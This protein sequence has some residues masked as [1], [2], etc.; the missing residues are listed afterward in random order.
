M[1]Q[2]ASQR[3]ILRVAGGRCL[4]QIDAIATEAPLELWI[5]TGRQSRHKRRLTTTLRTPTGHDFEWA[6]GFLWAESLIQK[7]SDVLSVRYISPESE[8]IHQVLVDLHPDIDID[9][10]R[11]QRFS[12]SNTACGLCGTTHFDHLER[13][14]WSKPPLHPFNV[15]AALLPSLPDKLRAAQSGFDTTG[16][17]HAAAL[18][19]A[20]GQLCQLREDI[21]RHNALD[22]L[23]GWAFQTEN[24]PLTD[25]ILVLSG[26]IGFELVQKAVVAHIPIVVAI[27]APS[28]LAVAYAEE[29]GLT[30]VGFLRQHR[31]NVYTHPERLLF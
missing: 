20:Q 7:R 19:D 27:G 26:R 24:L 6:V 1:R 17:L 21:G 18:F 15:S 9:D 22:K 16:G 31:F 4:S 14:I 10:E 30:M 23:V 11:Q 3:P 12:C 28:D 2:N 13:P 5:A 29:N 8:A 25:K